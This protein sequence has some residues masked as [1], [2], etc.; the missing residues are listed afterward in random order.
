MPSKSFLEKFNKFVPESEQ[1]EILNNISDYSLR[2]SKE[3][4]I[5]EA[6]IV[7]D[8]LIAKEKLYRIERG[9]ESAYELNH[10]KLLPKYPSELF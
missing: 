9:I 4:R 1:Y 7:M 10:V 5:I 2:V 6:V 3:K 8:K